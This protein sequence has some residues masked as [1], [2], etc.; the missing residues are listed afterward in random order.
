M[1][2]EIMYPCIDCMKNPSICGRRANCKV[3]WDWILIATS[4]LEKAEIYKWHDLRK[5]PNDLPEFG[6]EV[7]IKYYNKGQ[8]VNHYGIAWICDEENN[9]N[10]PN[11]KNLR[12]IKWKYIEL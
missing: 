9:W 1:N 2:E 4:A 5:D 3:Y 10:F 8:D 6:V 7:F 12:I 11:S